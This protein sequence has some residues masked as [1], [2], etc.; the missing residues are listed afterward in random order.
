MNKDQKTLSV[1]AARSMTRR[2]LV[3]GVASAALSLTLLAGCGGTPAATNEGSSAGSATK[4]AADTSAA[5]TGKLIVGFD[6]SYPP[7]GLCG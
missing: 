4:A 6:Q 2:S 5:A 3:A 7:Y 1:T